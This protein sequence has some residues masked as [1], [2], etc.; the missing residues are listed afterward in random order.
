MLFMTIYVFVCLWWCM[1]D[2]CFYKLM[3]DWYT[4][5]FCEMLNASAKNVILPLCGWGAFNGHNKVHYC[6][7][8]MGAVASQI[9]SLTI[10]YSSGHSGADQKK[11]QSSASLAFVRGIHRL[12]VN[13]PHKWPVTRKIF[14]FD[15]VIMKVC[16]I[17]FRFWQCPCNNS[18]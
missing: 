16:N 11:Y 5:V 4:N 3:F 12:P 8:I 6:D 2:V 17:S 13:F 10:V 14:P 15:V 1:V 9:T 7:V 18:M